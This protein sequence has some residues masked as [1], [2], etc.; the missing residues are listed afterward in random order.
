MIYTEAGDPKNE[1]CRSDQ[2]D[3]LTTTPWIRVPYPGQWGAPTFRCGAH[4][5]MHD[6]LHQCMYCAEHIFEL[7]AAQFRCDHH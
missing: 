4:A 5:C 2:T 1:F 7:A 6:S 3:V